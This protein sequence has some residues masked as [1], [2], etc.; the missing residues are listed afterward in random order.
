MI[1][2]R[3]SELLTFTLIGFASQSS[4]PSFARLAITIIRLWALPSEWL[5]SQKD[6]RSFYGIRSGRQPP[7]INFLPQ[8]AKRDSPLGGVLALVKAQ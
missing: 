6:F 8:K 5:P 3:H 4:F 1:K 7:M 2:E